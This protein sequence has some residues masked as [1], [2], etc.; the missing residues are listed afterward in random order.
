SLQNFTSLHNFIYYAN[1][2]NK[3]ANKRKRRHRT[4]FSE[5][6]LFKLESEFSRTHYPDVLTRENLALRIGLK[7]ER[8]EVWFKNRRAKWR[9]QK[10][11]VSSKS[12]AIDLSNNDQA[13]G[14]DLTVLKREATSNPVF[15]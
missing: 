12:E 11:D 4:I 10:K 3:D 8:V 14:C 5:E 6:Q 13:N 2:T 9:K 7:E 15:P 1:I